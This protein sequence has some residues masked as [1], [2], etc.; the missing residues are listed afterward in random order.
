MVQ[1]GRSRGSSPPPPAPSSSDLQFC[2][3]SMELLTLT[4][5]CFGSLCYLYSM[6]ALIL[7]ESWITDTGRHFPAF[8]KWLPH[9]IDFSNSKSSPG[10]DAVLKNVL[11]LTLFFL[12]HSVMARPTVKRRM[13]KAVPFPWERSLFCLASAAA[14]HLLVAQWVV[15]PTVL[16]RVPNALQPLVQATS[17][18]G[19]VQVQVK[20]FVF[21]C[22]LH[23]LP[24]LL[25][26]F[27]STKLPANNNTLQTVVSSFLIDHFS[28]FGLKQ[29]CLGAAYT[30]EAFQCNFLYKVGIL[31]MYGACLDIL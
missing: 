2:A 29:S 7:F 17:Y 28:L 25:V 5:S 24:V 31:L 18:V 19:V 23:M 20:P 22:M 14:L 27:Y 30:P 9:N 13:Q 26:T 16:W 15:F 21:I 4:R 8:R 6:Y 3:T 1:L 11:L 10:P 12:P